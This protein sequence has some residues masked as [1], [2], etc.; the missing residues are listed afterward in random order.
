VA[1]PRG[2]GLAERSD[3]WPSLSRSVVVGR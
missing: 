2:A 3:A 1:Q